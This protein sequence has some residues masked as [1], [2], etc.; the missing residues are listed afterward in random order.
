MARFVRI[1]L[2]TVTVFLSL[3]L[4]FKLVVLTYD[5]S[6]DIKMEK[7]NYRLSKDEY[8]LIKDGDIILRHGYGFVSDMIVQTLEEDLAI[9][10]CAI[11]VKNDSAINVIHSV[12]QTVSDFDGVQVQDI[13]QFVHES[14]MNSIIVL[15]YRYNDKQNAAS[16]SERASY[17]LDRRIPFDLS[18]NIEDTTRFFC[19]EFIWKVFLDALEVD[20]F[21]RKYGNNQKEFYKFDVFF[22]TELFEVVFSHH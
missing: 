10:H 13:R 14:K 15:R 9:S 22:D 5:Y 16:V 19:T 18:F 11:I 1:L 20:I 12:S 2:I 6:A 17:Y 4:I 7:A 8:K 3:L 21:E